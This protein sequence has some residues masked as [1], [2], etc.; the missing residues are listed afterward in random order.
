LALWP[1]LALHELG[2]KENAS[3]PFERSVHPTRA[4]VDQDQIY[5]EIASYKTNFLIEDGPANFVMTTEPTH[6]KGIALAPL[7]VNNAFRSRFWLG[8]FPDG[9]CWMASENSRLV[10]LPHPVGERWQE[11]AG[12]WAA[13]HML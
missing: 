2:P 7:H 5:D 1:D 8:L 12:C 11:W 10:P 6:A 3:F 4:T 13:I 9:A